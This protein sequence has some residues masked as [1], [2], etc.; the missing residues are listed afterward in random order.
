M[1]DDRQSFP[2]AVNETGREVQAGLA[3]GCAARA[4][5]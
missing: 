2:C 3:L 1:I 5:L 4:E